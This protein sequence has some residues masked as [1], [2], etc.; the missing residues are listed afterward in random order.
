MTATL[1]DD[2][3]R[4]R[5]TSERQRACQSPRIVTKHLSLWEKFKLGVRRVTHW[6]SSKLQMLQTKFMTHAYRHPRLWGYTKMFFIAVAWVMFWI[7]VYVVAVTAIMVVLSLL[8]LL[9][10]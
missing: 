9:V 5:S 1:H 7:M 3:I 6:C 2:F 8:G 4:R 10:V